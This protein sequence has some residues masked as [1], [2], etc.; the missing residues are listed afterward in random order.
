MQNLNNGR[1]CQNHWQCRSQ[2]CEL[3]VCKGLKYGDLCSSNV[4]CDQN[5]YCQTGFNWPWESECQYLRKTGDSCNEDY[6]CLPK[7]FCWYASEEEKKGD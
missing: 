3:G 6:D 2:K 4:D 7:D 5:L 1:P